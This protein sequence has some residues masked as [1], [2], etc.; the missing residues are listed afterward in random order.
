[1]K[2]NYIQILS[3]YYYYLLVGQSLDQQKNT[4]ITFFATNKQDLQDP[5]HD[6]IQGSTK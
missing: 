2:R 6:F 5:Q 4:T 3:V 1:M